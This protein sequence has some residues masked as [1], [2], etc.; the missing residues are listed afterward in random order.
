VF[1][2]KLKLE[3]I[4]VTRNHITPGHWKKSCF[5]I[6]EGLKPRVGEAGKV[7]SYTCL[8]LL[9]GM[10]WAFSLEN[11]F[12][13]GFSERGEVGFFSWWCFSQEQ[14]RRFL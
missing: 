12:L 11:G 4:E 9:G 13:S 5:R 6:P 1:S 8:L 3:A 10:D 7:R 2:R 14:L